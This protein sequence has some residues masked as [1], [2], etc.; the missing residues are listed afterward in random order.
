MKA[1]VFKG[2]GQ[3]LVVEDPRSRLDGTDGTAADL[4]PATSLR[5]ANGIDA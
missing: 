4:I 1:A 5:P 2:A 3:P